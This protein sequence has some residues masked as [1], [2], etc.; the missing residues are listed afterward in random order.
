MSGTNSSMHVFDK[1][2]NAGLDSKRR[3]KESRWSWQI[4]DSQSEIY[5]GILIYYGEVNGKVSNIYH[6]QYIGEIQIL[7]L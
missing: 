3:Y 7:N 5:R 4:I 2:K 1:K 6:G